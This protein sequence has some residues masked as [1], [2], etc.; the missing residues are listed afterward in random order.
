MGL[1]RLRVCGGQ[2]CGDLRS[3]PASTRSTPT[4]AGAPPRDSP[5][6]RRRRRRRRSAPARRR[7][8]TPPPRHRRARSSPGARRGDARPVARLGSHTRREMVAS[9]EVGVAQQRA[10]PSPRTPSLRLGADV[11]GGVAVPRRRRHRR[12]GVQRLRGK[13][14]RR[15]RRGGGRRRRLAVV[16]PER[17]VRCHGVA[18]RRGARRARA[19]ARGATP[20]RVAEGDA[21]R[22][23]ARAPCRSTASA[24]TSAEGALGVRR[25]APVSTPTNAAQSRAA[26]GVRARREDTRGAFGRSPTVAIAAAP[27]VAQR[28]T[29]RS[30]AVAASASEVSARRRAEPATSSPTM[31]VRPIAAPAR[32]RRAERESVPAERLKQKRL[33]RHVVSSDSNRLPASRGSSRGACAR[34]ARARPAGGAAQ[35]ARSL[36]HQR[37]AHL[38][39]PRRRWLESS[40]V[41]VATCRCAYVCVVRRAFLRAASVAASPG[42]RCVRSRGERVAAGTRAR[43]GPSILARRKRRRTSSPRRE[44]RGAA[45]GRA[46]VERRGGN[47]RADQSRPQRR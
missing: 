2:I 46:R 34:R 39:R 45:H 27:V 25:I 11:G 38:L 20:T 7:G 6:R 12:R 15:R 21:N 4:S 37:R 10:E 36:V 19:R 33:E 30:D 9:H 41:V 8:A 13:T 40:I 18:R 3:P 24:S 23:R 32:R 22:R 31:P 29:P 47:R 44:H 43:R 5:G 1:N 26:P 28:R 17:G 16:V 42:M 14:R 35:S